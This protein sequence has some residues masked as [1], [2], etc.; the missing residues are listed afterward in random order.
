MLG[1]QSLP[2]E[3]GRYYFTTTMNPSGQ[4]TQPFVVRATLESG[5]AQLVYQI[6]VD[7]YFDGNQ[8]DSRTLKL[9]VNI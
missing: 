7:F 6:T 9:T 8:F 2:T 5:I 1:N 3:G 4:T